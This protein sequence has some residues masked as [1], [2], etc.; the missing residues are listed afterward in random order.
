M[1]EK[2]IN[3]SSLVDVPVAI[4]IWIRENSLRLQFD[5]ICKARPSTL[6][7]ISDMGR[8][9]KEI[10]LVKSNR[11]YIEQ[12]I[13]WKCQ[14]YKI[15]EEKNIGLYLMLKK[16]WAYIWS[17][18]D[19]CIYLE[20]DLVPSVSFFEYC[21]VLL[22]KYKDDERIEAICGYNS[23]GKW[24]TNGADYFFSTGGSIW[25]YAT[26]KR[27]YLL[28][29][30]ISYYSNDKYFMNFVSNNKD[31]IKGL[32]TLYGYTVDS[33]YEGHIPGIEFWWFFN[34]FANNRMYIMPSRNM[35]SCYGATS[36]SENFDSYD[37]L[38]EYLK[39][40]FY[41]KTYEIAFPMKDPSFMFNDTDFEYESEKSIGLHQTS[42]KRCVI[43]KFIKKFKAIIKAVL[44]T[45]HKGKKHA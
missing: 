1:N 18:V 45:K 42:K 28:D 6:F 23:L 2:K 20:D 12:N 36:D 10:E 44:G 21:R 13:N 41:T 35:I 7:L 5:S 33:Q 16:A 19:R 26:W 43:S 17:Q 15:Y 29:K 37:K 34:I 39:K 31:K 3:I 40:L 14:V 8:N 30:N 24:E 9:E 22:E 32:K 27:C 4:N 25:G 38:P 11:C